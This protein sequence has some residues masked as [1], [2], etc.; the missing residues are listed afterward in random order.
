MRGTSPL[1]FSIPAGAA[2]QEGQTL[3]MWIISA[4]RHDAGADGA[5]TS[6]QQD[7]VV[8]GAIELA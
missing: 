7:F 2:M 5:G 8:Q 4:D 3:R 1:A 6:G